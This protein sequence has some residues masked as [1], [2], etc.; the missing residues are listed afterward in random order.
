MNQALPHSHLHHRNHHNHHNQSCPSFRQP[1]GRFAPSPTGALHLGSLTTAVASYCHIHSLA[2]QQDASQSGYQSNCQPKRQPKWLLRIEDVDTQ[3]CKSQ[4]SEQILTD[5]TNLGLHWDDE[6]LYQSVRTER[7]NHYIND[8]LKNVCYACACSRKQL[9]GQSIY[10]RNCVHK[11]LPISEHKVRIQLPNYLMGFYDGIQGVQWQNPQAS[12]GD[13]VI[14]RDNNSQN[15]INYILAVSIDDGLQGVTHA[16]RGLDIMPMTTAQIAIMQMA[17]LPAIDHWYHLPLVMNADGQ[18]LSKQNLAKPIDTSSQQK[19]SELLA[20]AL[21]FL[22]Q[23]KVDM[24]TP[25]RMLAQATSQW[26][27]E[28]MGQG[29]MEQ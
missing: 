8:E 17:H 22:Q 23:P 27:N 14:R 4:Y 9:K 5:L 1:V 29:K 12:L 13:M 28:K 24:D 16:M 11:Q 25:E 7:Y 26:N 19:C 15:M 2:N 20:E 21:A 18:K 3:R 6:V 10:P